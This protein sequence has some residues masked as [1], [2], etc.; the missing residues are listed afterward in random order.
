MIY[1]ECFNGSR[2]TKG[3]CSTVRGTAV[4]VRFDTLVPRVNLVESQIVD[5]SS[6]FYY[7]L[8]LGLNK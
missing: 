1:I 8:F 7:I 6:S 4:A 2:M 5:V 3:I